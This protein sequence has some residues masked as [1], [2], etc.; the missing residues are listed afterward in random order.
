MLENNKT[1]NSN[2]N[3]NVNII[4]TSNILEIRQYQAFYDL[5]VHDVHNDI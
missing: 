5:F 2:V 4:V 3:G 1:C